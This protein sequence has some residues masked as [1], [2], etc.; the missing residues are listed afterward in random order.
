MTWG[1]SYEYEGVIYGTQR[2][3]KDLLGKE[4][5]N[6]T[7]H[8]FKWIEGVP[9]KSTEICSACTLIRRTHQRKQK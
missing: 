5:C 8:I 4:V 7:Q 9:H 1:N 3:V 2:Q 6:P